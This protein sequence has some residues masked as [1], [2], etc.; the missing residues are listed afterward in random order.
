MKNQLKQ[1]LLKNKEVHCIDR[2][3][4]IAALVLGL[5]LA[6]QGKQVAKITKSY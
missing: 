5:E 6:A 1:V 3:S 4:H 2:K